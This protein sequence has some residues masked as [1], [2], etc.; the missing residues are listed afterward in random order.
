MKE[1]MITNCVT[2]AFSSIAI[3]VACHTTK[4]AMP[5]W[6]FLIVP[7]WTCSWGGDANK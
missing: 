5:L 7:R 6:A 3:A 4:S 1:T 2:M